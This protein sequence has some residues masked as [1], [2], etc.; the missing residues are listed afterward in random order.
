MNEQIIEDRVARLE[1]A[2]CKMAQNSKIF[3][4]N[5]AGLF[6]QLIESSEQNLLTLRLILT[7]G[8]IKS[9]DICKVLTDAISKMESKLD[10]TKAMCRAIQDGLRSTPP[11]PPGLP[12]SGA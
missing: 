9:D 11:S 6:E 12:A 1:T 3:A 10:Q 7:A 4:A 2:F 8:V 5:D